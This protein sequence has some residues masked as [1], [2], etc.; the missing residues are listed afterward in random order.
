[1]AATESPRLIP[2]R[3]ATAD[4]EWPA[5]KA[6]PPHGIRHHYCRIAVADLEPLARI[7]EQTF[8]RLMAA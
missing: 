8:D 1:M 2:A 5:G 6:L 7:Y 4:I 3:T